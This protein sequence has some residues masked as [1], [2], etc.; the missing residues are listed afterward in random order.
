MRDIEYIYLETTNHCNLRCSFCNREEVIG[1][2]KHMSLENW[3][4]V[5]GKLINQPIKEAKLMGLGE[6]FLHPQFDEITR[7]FKVSFPEAFTLA[8]TNAQYTINDVFRRTLKHLDILYISIDGYE[9]N[10]ERDR[11]PAKWDKLVRFLED[12]QDVDRHDCCIV[13]NYVVN[14][15]NVY[16]VEKVDRLRSKYNLE[17]LRLNIAQNWTEGQLIGPDYNDHQ[18]AYLKQYE[19]LIRGRSPWTYSDCFWPGKGMYMDVYG[20]VKVCCLNTSAKPIGNIFSESIEDIRRNVEFLDI[21][22]GCE[23]DSPTAHCQNCS[24]KELSPLLGRLLPSGST[25]QKATPDYN[26]LKRSI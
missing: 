23:T 11:A 26:R 10:Y 6:P 5:L 12:L 7:L 19:D 1:A 14:V 15:E 9:E 18:I 25:Y 2:L 17:E 20:N 24:Y 21:R 13:V 4:I 3:G 8:A 16:D 22:R